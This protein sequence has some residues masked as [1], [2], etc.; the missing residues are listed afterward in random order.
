MPRPYFA[1]TTRRS[2]S[3]AR[4][5]DRVLDLVHGA[6]RVPAQLLLP[7]GPDAGPAALLL[8]GFSSNKERMTQSVGRALQRRGVATLSLDL[9]FHG[10]RDGGREEIPYRNP[11]ALVAAWR[12]AVREAR[13]AIEWLAAQPEVDAARIGIV[14]YSLGG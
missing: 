13:G 9:P 4:G 5:T 3:T 7:A 12:T 1:A 10:E 11:L 8:H 6:E 2:T 14:G